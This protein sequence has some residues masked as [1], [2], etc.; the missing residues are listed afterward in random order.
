MQLY[1]GAPQNGLHCPVRELKG[2][3]KVFLQPGESRAVAFALTDRSFAVWQDGWK[4]PGGAYTVCIGD[5]R[6]LVE[7]SGECLPVPAWQNGSWYQSCAGKPGQ[8]EWETM[9]GRAYMPPV[10][11]K[12]SFTMENS[13]EEMKDY[14]L[15]M[16]LMYRATE[17]VIAR[18]NG[19]KLDREDPTFR[20]QMAASAGGPLRSMM[21]SGGIR[22]SV[23]PGLLEMANGRFLRGIWKM[24]TG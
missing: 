18:G 24:L 15:V 2:F 5:L 9:L 10:L 12:G 14:S 11:K 16:K 22:G 13:V 19:G 3:Q 17:R 21:I 1:I 8:K 20:M 4:I 23:M 7:R 6:A